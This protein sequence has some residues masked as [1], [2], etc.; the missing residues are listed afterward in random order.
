MGIWDKL[1]DGSF[2]PHGH[3]LLWLPD[4]LFLHVT[5]DAL[6]V[7]AYFVIPTALVY[8]VNKRADL[9]FNWIFIMFAAFIFLCGV[10]HL[11]SLINIWHG[12]YY[13]EGI[14]K[15]ATGLISTLTAVMVW[16]LVPA[17]LA[18]PSNADF[19]SK[20]EALLKAQNELLAANQLL[21]Q[22]VLE[23]TRELEHQARTDALTGILNRG[24]LMERLK[25]EIDRASRY[26]QK[27]SVLMVDL[28]H[29]KD[30][31][32]KFGH[33]TGDAVLIEMSN[34]LIKAARATDVLGRFGGEEYLLVLP[35]TDAQSARQL[36]ERIR[37]D[38]EQHRFVQDD[39]SYLSLT[40]SI[41]VTELCADQDKTSLLQVVDRMLYD[42]KESG[43][44]TVVVSDSDSAD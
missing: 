34:L 24:G 23:R 21:E 19:R 25:M 17:A 44:N 6:T 35:E 28:D 40:C 10:T 42:A 41:G 15:L 7:I 11:L 3:C 29:F 14:S 27:L 16:R 33:L 32:D 26:H 1:L 22:R 30:V 9:A 43:R 13:I 20:N 5:G 8:L 2:M 36:A 18:I 39:G 4:L 37:R 31:N 38:V 12:Y